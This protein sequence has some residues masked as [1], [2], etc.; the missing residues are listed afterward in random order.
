M[1]MGIIVKQLSDKL[2]AFLNSNNGQYNVTSEWV[3]DWL[4]ENKAEIEAI[5]VDS[6]GNEISGAT[7]LIK[8][9]K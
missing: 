3:N 1:M 9:K 2:L 5:I 7:V 6:N 4:S 8:Q